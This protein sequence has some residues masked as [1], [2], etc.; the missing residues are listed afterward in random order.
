MAETTG[1]TPVSH[2]TPPDSLRQL[3]H[4]DPVQTVFTTTDLVRLVAGLVHLCTAPITKLTPPL[5]SLH[6]A[7]STYCRRYGDGAHDLQ[8]AAAD[9]STST[10]RPVM[11]ITD[12]LLQSHRL[13][14]LRRG[15]RR[16]FHLDI[17]HMELLRCRTTICGAL[18]V[19]RVDSPEYLDLQSRSLMVS[20]SSMS[21]TTLRTHVL[22]NDDCYGC[23][24]SSDSDSVCLPLRVLSSRGVSA[25]HMRPGQT[26]LVSPTILF[27]EGRSLQPHAC[28][29]RGPLDEI[30]ENDPSIAAIFVLCTLLLKSMVVHTLL[31]VLCI[32]GVL[33]PVPVIF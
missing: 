33:T 9:T 2:S 10:C 19:L 31:G 16:R 21:K 11:T 6:Q 3:I 5:R 28:S 12:I 30:S 18:S 26:H 29:E 1:S 20:A 23:S 22:K 14:P 27:L 4:P 24:D 7:S 8:L 13:S 32:R 15:R 17:N 25:Y